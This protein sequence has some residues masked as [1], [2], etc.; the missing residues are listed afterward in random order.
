MLSKFYIAPARGII[1]AIHIDICAATVV[2]YSDIAA[3]VECDN[4]SD[5]LREIKS[6][7]DR[8]ECVKCVR[9]FAILYIATCKAI[10]Y[11]KA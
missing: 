4:L 11:W 9:S 3:F 10:S 1:L 7:T 5:S 2:A 8:R 6:I